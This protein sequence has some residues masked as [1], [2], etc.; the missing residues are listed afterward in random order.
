MSDAIFEQ[1]PMKLITR[2]TL[3]DGVALVT[4]PVGN[5]PV[6][7]HLEAKIVE[8][9]DNDYVGKSPRLIRLGATL[10]SSITFTLVGT[11]NSCRKILWPTHHKRILKYQLPLY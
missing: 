3:G 8:V 9:R 6:S 2:F 7:Y 4:F 1:A 11:S 5:P 10:S